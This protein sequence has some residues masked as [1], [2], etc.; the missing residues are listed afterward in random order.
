MSDLALIAYLQFSI[1]QIYFSGD[2]L[3]CIFVRNTIYV[4]KIEMFKPVFM[5]RYLDRR[6]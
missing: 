2:C 5:A 3:F 1:G 4:I 6:W